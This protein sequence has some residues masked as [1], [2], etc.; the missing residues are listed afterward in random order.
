M[1]AIAAPLPFLRVPPFPRADPVALAWPGEAAATDDA[2]A[3]A[4]ALRAA[5]VGGQ[6]WGAQ[7]ALPSVSGGLVVLAPGS[8][9]QARAMLSALTETGDDAVAAGQAVLAGRAQHGLPPMPNV[10]GADPWW[11][12]AQ[13]RLVLADADAEIALAAALAGC[14]VRT[15][16]TGRF[17]DVGDGG[18]ALAAAID[19]ELLS[20]VSYRNPFT[21]DATTAIATIV[22]LTEWRTMIDSNRIIAQVLGVAGWKLATVEALVWDGASGRRHKRPAADGTALLWRSHVPPRVQQQVEASAASIA[23]IEDGFI[24][25]VGLGANCV[26]PLSIVIDHRGV[27]FDPSRPSDLEQLLEGHR[28][29]AALVDRAAALACRIV[30][31]GVSKYGRG[32]EQLAR[33]GGARRHVLVAGQVEDDRSVTLG[34][35][36]KRNLDLLQ[37]A[38]DAEPDAYLIYKPHPDVEAGHRKGAIDDTVALRLADAIER[39]ATISALLDMVDAVHVLT[40][41]AGFEAL[42]RGKQVFTHGTPFYAGWGLTTDLGAIPTRRTARRTLEE[43]VAATLILYPRYLDP[44]TRLP[45]PVEVLLDRMIAGTAATPAPLARLRTVQGSVR[46]A[47]MRIGSAL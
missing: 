36:G 9:A 23:E 17:A 5:R 41:L 24:R 15:F 27:H 28:F 26:P 32:N 10:D 34:G 33:P 38:R 21:G 18:S 6:F 3:V 8:A 35:G 30:E 13:A 43:L 14:S 2:A 37:A 39:E 16:G 22:Q 19:R 46:R 12:V 31:S 1:Q 11:L 7:P 40:S 20:G 44:V 45:C 47:F 29:D 25:S 4:D 42:L